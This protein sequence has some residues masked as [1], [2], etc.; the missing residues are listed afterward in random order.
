MIAER[1]RF[2]PAEPS[3]TSGRP[4]R[5]TTVGAIID[6]I[7][8]P[9]SWRWKPSGFRSCS[10]SMLFRCMPVPG[11]DHAEH[12]PFEQVTVAQSPSSSSTEM[13]VVDP[14]L[15]RDAVRGRLERLVAMKR[16]R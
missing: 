14:S 7:R 13:W 12:E 11:D 1:I 5:S 15:R 4:S 10:P 16:S 3:A 6:G 9:R 8:R 2:E